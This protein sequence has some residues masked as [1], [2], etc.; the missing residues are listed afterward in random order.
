V[1][2]SFT[3]GGNWNTQRK[4][5]TYRKSLTNFITF[6]FFETLYEWN[7]CPIKINTGQTE[8]HM[9]QNKKITTEIHMFQNKTFFFIYS[10]HS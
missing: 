7:L 8:I 1:E 3:G 5:L 2:V 9:F 10:D 6:N 4:P